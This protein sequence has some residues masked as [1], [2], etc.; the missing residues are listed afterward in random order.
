MKVRVKTLHFAVGLLH[1]HFF[2]RDLSILKHFWDQSKKSTLCISAQAYFVIHLAEK[3]SSE[4]FDIFSQFLVYSG[5]FLAVGIPFFI[6]SLVTLCNGGLAKIRRLA[7][8]EHINIAK[9]SSTLSLV[10]VM[11]KVMVSVV[12]MLWQLKIHIS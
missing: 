4:H 3:L 12:K 11:I 5:F 2:G 1:F 6:S 10:E 9:L 8:Y 7:A